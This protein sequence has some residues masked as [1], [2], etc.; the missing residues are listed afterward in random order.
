MYKASTTNSLPDR[1]NE[2]FTISPYPRK[3]FV[4]PVGGSHLSEARNSPKLI[5]LK[6]ISPKTIILMGYGHMG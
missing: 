5:S 3:L 1:L 4:L 2:I 6:S